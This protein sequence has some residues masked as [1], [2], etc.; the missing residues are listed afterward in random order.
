MSERRRVV[1]L[2]YDAEEAEARLGGLPAGVQVDAWT[3]PEQLPDSAGEVEL[4]V[5]PYSAGSSTL[6]WIDRLPALRVLQ[7]QTAGYE[8]VLARVPAGVTL[9]NGGGIH[10]TATAEL[11]ITLALASRRRLDRFARAQAEARW[12][13]E[14][15]M[16]LADQRIGIVGYGRIGQAIERRLAGFEVASVTRF[17]RTVRT[18]PDVVSITELPDRLP[19]LD[20]VFVITPLTEQTRGLFDAAMLAR[21]ADGALLINVSR[22]P[23]IDT[24]ALLAETSAGRIRAALD[25]TDPEPLPADHPLWRV[26]DVLISPHVGGY[27]ASFEPRRDALIA[28]QLRRFA[29]G[30]PV[31]NVV[32]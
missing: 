21:M 9:C 5:V 7:L 3:D 27:A 29:A 1:W 32:N 26:P 11:A 22:G 17:A 6:D 2:P 30:E 25:V 19:E 24:E 16:T 31:Q 28:A 13:P 12:A 14:W 8:D 15:G 4:A 20:V 18:D 10:D 23:V